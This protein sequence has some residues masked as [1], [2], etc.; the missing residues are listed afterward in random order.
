MFTSWKMA[1]A[2]AAGN[3][4]VMKPAELTPLSSLRVAELMAEAGFPKAVVNI[5]PGFGNTAGQYIP[6]IPASTRSPSPAECGC[7]AASIL[8]ALKVKAKPN[9]NAKAQRTQKDAKEKQEWEPRRS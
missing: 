2:L 1:P 7:E 8:S 9:F 5:L 6:S 3:C 4:V